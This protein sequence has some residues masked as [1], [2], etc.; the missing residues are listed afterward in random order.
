MAP[1][2]LTLLPD[3]PSVDKLP[4]RRLQ[5]ASKTESIRVSPEME[6]GRAGEYLVLADLLLSG[7][8]AYP[9]SQGVPYDVVVDIGKRIIR[10]QVKSTLLPKS[11]EALRRGTPLYMFHT[12]RTG[13]AGTRRYGADDFDMLA[14][15]GL[16]RRLVAYFPFRESRNDCI[17]IRVP[18]IC[19]GK[20]GV[21][22]RQF[23]EA[24]FDRALSWVLAD[25]EAR[26]E[27]VM[28]AFT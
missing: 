23:D 2:Q 11:P 9:T 7:W 13:K 28:P 12:R 14:L 24:S 3:L 6:A 18:G 20:G 1:Q 15:V 25:S 19:Y 27:K 16:D 10:I 5:I 21:R 4:L 17:G 22:Y 8:V 26:Q